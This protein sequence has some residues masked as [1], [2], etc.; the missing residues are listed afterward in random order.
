MELRH[1]AFANLRRRKG[2]AALI[3]LGLAVAVAAF[4][5]VLSLILSLRATMDDR[6]SKYG[7]NMV[8]TPRSEQLSLS[9][10]GLSVSGVASGEMALLAEADLQAL[11]QLPSADQVVAAVP[12]LLEPVEVSGRNFLAMGTDIAAGMKVKLWWRYEG[13]LPQAADEVLLGLNVR[14]ELGLQRGDTI[15]V[16]G[17]ELRVAGILWETGGEEDNL[18]I[19][20]RPLLEQISG[21]TGELNLIEVT[22]AS[23]GQV[24]ALTAE[25]EGMLP[26]A[27]VTSVKKSIEFTNQANGSLADFG[28]A[29]TF[30]VMVI[31]GIVVTITML[32]AIKERQKEIGILRAVGYKQKHIGLLVLQESALLSIAAAAS[33]VLAGLLGGWAAPRVV[34]ELS[35]TFVFSPSV[36]LAGTLAAFVIGL[37][38]ALYPAYR[39]A[40]LDPAT[41][42]KYV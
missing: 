20:E 38:A 11:Q 21:R 1:V 41:A 28:L 39:A 32:S 22:A 23:S 15:E 25:I 14:N 6:L 8:V 7:S 10:G 19:M 33:G 42:L 36:V 27:E 5:L 13:A 35:L 2:K 18:I 4:V 24:D 16:A 12:V 29:L 37:A 3:T 9:Y 30:L 34:P 31:C 26:A 40:N 17:R